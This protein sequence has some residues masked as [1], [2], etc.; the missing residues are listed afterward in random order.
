MKLTTLDEQDLK[1]LLEN[2][3]V[4]ASVS[5]VNFEHLDHSFSLL[6][7]I[8]IAHL[9]SRDVRTGASVL[10]WGCGMGQMS[11]LMQRRG[12]QVTSFDVD[13]GYG[14]LPDLPLT[15]TFKR[16]LGEHATQL[17]FEDRSFDAVL[18]CGVLEHVDEFSE[19]GNELKSLREIARILNE[20]GQL[21]IYQLPQQLAWQ[22][23]LARQL[24]LGYCHPRRYTA[25]E[26]TGIL[27][28]CGF[29]VLTLRRANLIPR[30]LTGLP[31]I[32]RRTYSRFSKVLSALDEVLCRIPGLNRFAGVLEITAVKRA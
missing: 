10:D 17:P 15:Q 29:D 19:K 7:Y 3:R 12:L 30:N 22:E 14:N 8:R 27:T 6:S 25:R 16:I 5:T 24:R 2:A 18:S 26:I 28:T 9:I 31:R 21:L 32:V 20:R 13:A 1:F 11:Y 4:G 23:A